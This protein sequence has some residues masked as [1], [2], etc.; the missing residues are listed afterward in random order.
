M[1]MFTILRNTKHFVRLKPSQ[2]PVLSY[3]KFAK[4]K[5]NEEREAELQKRRLEIVR[6]AVESAL[7]NEKC[8]PASKW[9]AI[10]TELE[11]NP[12]LRYAATVQKY[13]FTILLSLRPNDSLQN[14][15]TFIESFGLK[16]EDLGIR[17]FIIQVYAKKASSEQL[18]ATEE[19]QVIE[20]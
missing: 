3:S 11:K 10:M 17:R 4:L 18:T 16:Y 15:R 5:S 7:R 20:W 12:E 2:P 14:A 6:S 19:Q 1:N 13:I 9:K 8:L